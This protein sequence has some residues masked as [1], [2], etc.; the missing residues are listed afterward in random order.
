[1]T[2]VRVLA[3][4]AAVEL[5]ALCIPVIGMALGHERRGFASGTPVRRLPDR[6]M[7]ARDAPAVYTGGKNIKPA[8]AMH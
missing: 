7:D 2:G 3:I 5:A 4:A 8:D 1:M 6:S